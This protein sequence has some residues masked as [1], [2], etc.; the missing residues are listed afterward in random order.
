MI[1]YCLKTYW[2]C[3]GRWTV[4]SFL[5]GA[6]KAKTH[7][8]ESRFFLN[9]QMIVYNPDSGEVLSTPVTVDLGQRLLKIGIS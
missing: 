5:K 2:S 4:V 7:K 8:Y 6:K 3:P 9:T 1:T